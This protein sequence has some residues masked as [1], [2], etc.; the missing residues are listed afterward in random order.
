MKT[1]LLRTFDILKIGR[2][3]FNI[4]KIIHGNYLSVHAEMTF[5]KSYQKRFPTPFNLMPNHEPVIIDNKLL[6]HTFSSFFFPSFFF[7]LSSFLLSSFVLSSFL[8]SFFHSF[9]MHACNDTVFFS[10]YLL[11]LMTVCKIC[12]HVLSFL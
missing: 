1:Y 12:N 5:K 4:V 7:L 6:T 2:L 9:Y 11:L 10:H 3:I 8:L